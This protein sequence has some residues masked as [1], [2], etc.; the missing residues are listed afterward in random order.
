[1]P[2]CIIERVAGGHKSVPI[3][4][5]E[6]VKSSRASREPLLRQL[7]AAPQRSTRTSN[8]RTLHLGLWPFVDEFD[9]LDALNEIKRHTL[10]AEQNGLLGRRDTTDA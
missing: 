2:S 1:M 3:A 10:A 4:T 5:A 6:L 9:Q 8:N 7:Q